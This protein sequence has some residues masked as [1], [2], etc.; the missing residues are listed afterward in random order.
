MTKNSELYIGIMSGT[1]LDG[2]DIALC[3]F[4]NDSIA[5]KAFESYTFDDELKQD[6]L[7]VINETTTLKEIG[8]VDDRLGRIYAKYIAR[9]LEKYNLNSNDIKAI[10]LHGQTVWHEPSERFSM[11]LGNPN[12]VAYE[13]GIAV[14]CDIRR[15]DMASGGQGAPFAPLFHK[16]LFG[17]LDK[18]NA[19]V[20]IGG[21]ANIS[22][23]NDE[24]IGYDTGCGNVLLD[25]WCDKY[26]G[27]SYD[28]NGEIARSGEINNEL[29]NLMLDDEYFKKSYPKSTGR[30]YFNLAWVKSKIIATIEPKDILRTLTE[31]TAKSIVNEAKKF[32]IDEIILCGGGV[33]NGFLVERIR[34]LFGK[35]VKLTSDHGVSE[36]AI[37]AMMMAY[38]AYLRIHKIPAQLGSVTGAKENLIAGG[39]Y[40]AN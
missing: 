6:I 3:E 16:F 40:E 18:K 8:G 27:L 36:D 11:Q 25:G 14:V 17:D 23:L 26:F 24:L 19:V 32:D 22:I 4:E 33:K 13:T 2:V 37:E 21:M 9:F 29:L 10:G 38:F 20:N 1:S 30:E 31:L 35:E 34:D 12:R 15:M 39:L 5:L 7:R 28:K